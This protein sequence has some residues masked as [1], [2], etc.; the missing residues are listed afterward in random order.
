MVREFPRLLLRE[1]Q[2]S[3][4][5]AG[6]AAAPGSTADNTS[7]LTR[8]DGGGYWTC[9]VSDVQ[10]SGGRAG[11]IDRQRQKN[12]TLLWR[13][14]RQISNGGATP[15]IV[16]RNDALFVPW[17]NG[18]SRGS[19]LN[20]SHEDETLFGDG[21][22]YYQAV[23]DITA[24]EDADLRAISMVLDINV[25]GE[26]VGGEAF[27]I[28]H[29]TMDWRMY[30][31]ATVDMVSDTEA[32]VTFNPPLREAVPAGTSIEFDRPRCKMRLATPSSMDLKVAPWTFNN[33]SVN[34][35]ESK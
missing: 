5:L 15:L 20:V 23:I 26:L 11:A 35:V 3:W 16:P 27:S 12:A 8:S 19:G 25:A 10:L 32:N 30:E 1:K 22:G 33:A 21:S 17:P 31:I 2:H 34:F 7:V 4:N 14:I 6:V 24:A 18:V 13:A 28:Q 9:A 29:P